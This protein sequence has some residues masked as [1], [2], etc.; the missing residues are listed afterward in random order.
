MPI[1][2]FISYGLNAFDFSTDYIRR[3][4]YSDNNFGY[5]F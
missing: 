3:A 1:S 5:H 4:S 2:T